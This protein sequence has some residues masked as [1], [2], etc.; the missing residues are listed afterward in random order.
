M[1][2]WIK[3]HRGLK[4]NWIF[5]DAE[6]F[7][8]WVYILMT[9]N[10]ETAPVK[11]EG[12]KF[13]CNRGES[14]KSLDTWANEFGGKWNKGKVNRLFKALQKAEMITL[15]NEKKTT[16]LTVCNYDK[17]QSNEP[18][19]TTEKRTATDTATDTA[20]RTQNERTTPTETDSS[21]SDPNGKR[22]A[23][24]TQ[25][26]RKPEPIKEVKKKE[27]RII[28]NSNTD[29]D[30]FISDFNTITGKRFRGDK[31]SKG[32]LNARLSE[33]FTLEEIKTAIENC[34][35]DKYHIENPNY[36]TPEFITRTDKLQKYLNASP[37]PRKTQQGP[38]Q[39][40]EPQGRI[41]KI[42]KA[43]IESAQEL[44]KIVIDL[45]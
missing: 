2:G 12:E 31:K 36:L 24:R 32:Q 33:G 19:N 5:A 29:F 25:T 4:D 16:R 11:I 41:E 15:K 44:E 30:F 39:D 20:K 35:S 14:L 10:Y 34:K 8:A 18:E 6:K 3:I 22:T 1:I 28:N 26:E 17:Y 27:D 45:S 42:A 9:V 21:E 37:T 43:A 23:K 40:K 13:I 38:K 7:K